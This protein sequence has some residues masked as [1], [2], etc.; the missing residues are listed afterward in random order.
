MLHSTRVSA[1]WHLSWI[2]REGVSYDDLFITAWGSSIGDSY[3]TAIGFYVSN[4]RIQTGHALIQLS[5]AV[6]REELDAAL[7]YYGF[8]E[9]R[10]LFPVRGHVM[11]PKLVEKLEYSHGTFA[12]FSVKELYT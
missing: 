6:T 10:C 4:M 1:D 8:E 7:V 11:P 2:M 12:S 3:V 9:K 5:R